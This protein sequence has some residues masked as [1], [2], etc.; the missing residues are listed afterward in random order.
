MDKSNINK[1]FYKLS[2]AVVVSGQRDFNHNNKSHLSL[3][4]NQGDLQKVT[5]VAR[6]H[7][8]RDK[9]KLADI[10]QIELDE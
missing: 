5:G 10:R 6:R 7:T 1:K 9:E 4:R 2:R 3:Q 8:I